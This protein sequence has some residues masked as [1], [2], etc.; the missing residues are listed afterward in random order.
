[1]NTSEESARHDEDEVFST[2]VEMARGGN[3][4]ERQS[5]IEKIHED[6]VN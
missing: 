4:N 2:F 1:M 3:G 6:G 5:K